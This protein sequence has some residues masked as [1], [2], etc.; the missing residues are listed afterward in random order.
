[1]VGMP[2]VHEEVFVVLQETNRDIPITNPL[3]N[4][5]YMHLELDKE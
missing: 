1:M 5:G 4:L 3:N 2:N